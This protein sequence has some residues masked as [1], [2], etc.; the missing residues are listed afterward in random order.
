MNIDRTEI[1]LEKKCFEIKNLETLFC[2][3]YA[4]LATVKI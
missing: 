4:K 2:C 3:L 1:A